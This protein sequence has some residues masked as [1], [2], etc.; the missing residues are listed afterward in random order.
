MT[1][2]LS[3]P[4]TFIHGFGFD[5]ATLICSDIKNKELLFEDS[6][7]Q[8]GIFE[9]FR[10]FKETSLPSSPIAVIKT[11]NGNHDKCQVLYT[12]AECQKTWENNTR[13]GKSIIIQRFVYTGKFP[14]VFQVNFS[15]DNSFKV[16]HCKKDNSMVKGITQLLPN[17]QRNS[18]IK[19]LEDRNWIIKKK[20]I[21]KST[22]V[23]AEFEIKKQINHLGQ[24]IE[25]FYS[26]NKGCKLD[27]LE[28]AWLCDKSDNFFLINIKSYRILNIIYKPIQMKIRKPGKN[29]SVTRQNSGEY[30]II[31]RTKKTVEKF[32][33]YRTKSFGFKSEKIVKGPII[34]NI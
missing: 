7:S 6:L 5:K 29:F 13:Q 19:L 15:L 28:T 9:G 21:V 17:L 4:E 8:N 30:R 3:I 23:T 1:I 12:V 18:T 20:D 24:V 33:K 26:S 14:K 22:E 10:Y 31:K 32:I 2:F 11:Q 16:T 25:K 27:V 34:N